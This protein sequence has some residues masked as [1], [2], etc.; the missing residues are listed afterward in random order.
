MLAAVWK[1]VA[2]NSKM[3]DRTDHMSPGTDQGK[4]KLEIF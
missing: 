3:K 2:V 4:M 1:V